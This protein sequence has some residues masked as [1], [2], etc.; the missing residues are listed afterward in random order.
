MKKLSQL[1]NSI[2]DNRRRK[3]KVRK[4]STVIINSFASK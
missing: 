2:K 3:N 1:I 4:E